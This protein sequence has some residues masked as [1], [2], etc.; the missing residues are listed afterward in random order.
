MLRRV[1]E[2]TVAPWEFGLAVVLLLVS[3]GIALFAAARIY[4]AGVLLYGQRASLREV[5]KAARV[6][7]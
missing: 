1:A 6:S 7:R 3:I 2:G 5:M 4:S